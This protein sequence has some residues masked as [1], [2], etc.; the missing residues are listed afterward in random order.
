MSILRVFNKVCREINAIL[1]EFR[2]AYRKIKEIK[3]D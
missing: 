3:K 1:L 2:A